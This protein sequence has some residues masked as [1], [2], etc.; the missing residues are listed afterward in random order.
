VRFI[1]P[2]GIKATEAQIYEEQQKII[3]QNGVIEDTLGK[4]GVRIYVVHGND[5]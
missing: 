1:L 2:S 5:R 3:I 4:L